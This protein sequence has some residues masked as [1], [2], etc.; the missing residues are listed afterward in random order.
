MAAAI[1]VQAITPT[2]S[3][4]SQDTGEER[5]LAANNTSAVPPPATQAVRRSVSD[6]TVNTAI[7]AAGNR[8]LWP[9]V[10]VI[11][12]AVPNTDHTSTITGH[13]RR[14]SSRPNA[15]AA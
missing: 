13:R 5:K 3:G 12:T 1:P 15:I 10:S 2:F 7:T 6:A 9:S 11:S 14:T 8:A 4:A